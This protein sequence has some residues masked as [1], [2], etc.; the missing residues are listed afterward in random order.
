VREPLRK[1]HGIRE[2]EI[3]RLMTAGG[4]HEIQFKEL[5]LNYFGPTYAGVYRLN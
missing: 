1:E 2:D 5:Q 3:R 4:L